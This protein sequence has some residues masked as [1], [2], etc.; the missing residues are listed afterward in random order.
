MTS[1]L[2]FEVN[3]P[4]KV[5]DRICAQNDNQRSQIITDMIV[6]YFGGGIRN[7][8]TAF[9]GPFRKMAT[10]PFYFYRGSALLFYQGL[11]VDKDSWIS[12]H[13]LAGNIFIYVKK[14]FFFYY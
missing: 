12:F 13:P 10:T 7:N 9:H 3:A 1:R 11:K 6:K 5:I 4:Q 8:P 14:I 2:S